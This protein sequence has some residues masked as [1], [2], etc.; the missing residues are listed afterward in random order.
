MSRMEIVSK[1]DKLERLIDA[2]DYVNSH[3]WNV[4][5][6]DD[7]PKGLAEIAYKN[8]FGASGE[9]SDLHH[10]I[11]ERSFIRQP[12]YDSWEGIIE[13]YFKPSGNTEWWYE[14]G[15]NPNLFTAHIAYMCSTVIIAA[16]TD[17]YPQKKKNSP[18]TLARKQTTV[19]LTD[20]GVL[21]TNIK[22]KESGI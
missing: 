18:Y 12:L 19:A 16:I 13:Q 9:S 20:K 10:D 14:L 5:V 8:E 15:A 17:D 22:Y 7:A 2:S 21:E 3:I 6:L 1:T 11:P 4:G